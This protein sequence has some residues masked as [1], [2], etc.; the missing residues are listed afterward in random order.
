MYFVVNFNGF[1]DDES[2]IYKYLWAGGKSVCSQDVVNFSD[3]HGFL[4]S[5]KH[6]TNNGIEKNLHLQVR[7]FSIKRLL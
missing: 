3:P 1:H 2:G 4:H 7:K 6:W 5:D